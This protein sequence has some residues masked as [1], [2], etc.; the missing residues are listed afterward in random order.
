MKYRLKV[1][2]RYIIAYLFEM[3]AVIAIL[4]STD[5]FSLADA[6]RFTTAIGVCIAIPLTLLYYRTFIILDK[7]NMT[8]YYLGFIKKV[9]SLEDVEVISKN[10]S[11]GGTLALSSDK[12][13][14]KVSEK[15]VPISIHDKEQFLSSIYEYKNNE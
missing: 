7:R 13:L 15:E 2:K 11:G 1:G 12:L 10:F 3:I 14:L 4:S 8:V 6:L 5:T 9:V